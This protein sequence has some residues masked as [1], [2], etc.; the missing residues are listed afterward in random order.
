MRT[1]YP[2]SFLAVGLFFSLLIALPTEAATFDINTTQTGQAG[3]Y[4]ERFHGR[5]TASGERYNHRDLTAAHRMLPFGTKVKV[6]NKS[7]GRS[8]IVRIN[9][10]G[11]FVK[12]R[13]IDLSG[14]AARQLNLEE[15]ER[16]LVDVLILDDQLA[17]TKIPTS[18]VT[19]PPPAIA[20]GSI[21]DD[22]E[23]T[24]TDTTT[25]TTQTTPAAP[26]ATAPVTARAGSAFTVQLGS[27]KT[28]AAAETFSEDIRHTWIAPVEIAETTH[29]RVYYGR[30]EQ[31][32]QAEWAKKS[33]AKRGFDGFI[34]QITLDK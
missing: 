7:N 27:F 6:T 29:Y 25:A 13:M 8:V 17:P 28:Q 5:L 31:L 26:T 4:V 12:N 2:L 22:S 14:E 11:P 19:M 18:G 1:L 9:D 30:F 20:P 24:A 15:G 33:L 34:K 10:R 23:T 16:T 3:T 32:A 21:A